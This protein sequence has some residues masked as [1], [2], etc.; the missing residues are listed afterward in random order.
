MTFVSSDIVGL[1]SDT[2]SYEKIICAI[3]TEKL[4]KQE[5]ELADFKL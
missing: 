2:E 3:V 1:P 4:V 5:F